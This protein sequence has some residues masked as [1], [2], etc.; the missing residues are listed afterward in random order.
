MNPLL[1][2]RLEV[3][4][5]LMA[6]INNQKI[7][8]TIF[9]LHQRHLAEFLKD[10]RP[11]RGAQGPTMANSKIC[12]LIPIKINRIFNKIMN[13]FQSDLLPIKII[14]IQIK[15][16]P[17]MYINNKIGLL[18]YNIKGIHTNK[19]PTL[20]F[21]YPHIMVTHRVRYPLDHHHNK[22]P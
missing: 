18:M 20:D 9:T 19:S 16:D 2:L 3:L 13:S 15:I 8:Q 14:I 22:Y 7:N 11:Q 5:L 21:P 6:S 17:L 12:P 1:I 10:P 4:E